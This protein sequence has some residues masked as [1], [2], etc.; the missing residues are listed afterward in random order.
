MPMDISTPNTAE[1]K[2]ARHHRKSLEAHRDGNYS[3]LD[4]DVQ[5]DI[6]NK[7]EQDLETLTHGQKGHVPLMFCALGAPAVVEN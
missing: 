4:A 7:L 2:G 6:I 3:G 1:A 5:N